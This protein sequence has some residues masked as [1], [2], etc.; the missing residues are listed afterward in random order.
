MT[1]ALIECSG[2]I[3]DRV[4]V[5]SAEVIWQVSRPRVSRAEG[6]TLSWPFDLSGR[7]RAGYRVVNTAGSILMSEL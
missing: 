3:V 4:F 1:R 2:L 5:L 7:L 6:T